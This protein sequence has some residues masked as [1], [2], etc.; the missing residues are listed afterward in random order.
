MSDE[1]EK[2]TA[3]T[4]DEVEGHSVG[5][6]V[7]KPVTRPIAAQDD[8][9]ARTSRATRCASRWR[10]RSRSPS[11]STT[12]SLGSYS[13]AGRASRPRLS[14]RVGSAGDPAA[15]RSL[16]AV[17]AVFAS[18]D[19][20]RLQLAGFCGQLGGW[21][22]WIVLSLYAYDHGGAVDGRRRRRRCGSR[23][24]RSRRRSRASIADRFPR[25][26]VL[27][28]ADTTRAACL[29]SR[30]RSTPPTG[31]RRRDR[32][33]GALR[34]RGHGVPAGALGAPAD[35]R[36]LA[37]GADRLERDRDGD[38]EREPLRSGR[39]SAA[40]SSRPAAPSPASGS[41]PAASRSR[42][43]L[44]SGSRT[45]EAPL[46]AAESAERV[47]AAAADGLRAITSN[48]GLA[49]LVG[50]FVAQ[51]FVSG[52]L[53]VLTVVLATV[54]LGSGARAGR[55]PELGDRASAASSARSARSA[56]SAAAG[57]RPCSGS[58]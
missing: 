31:R 13:S 30:R 18:P 1:N 27:L 10:S 52:A 50:L 42:R 35:A 39:R 40:S 56:S 14:A 4:D 44:S 2:P 12:F 55:L 34:D 3:K 5:K 7:A 16:S 54:R 15:R 26:R 6:P 8:D 41:A 51:T 22:Y 20:R 46:G 33:R 11:S 53:G 38:R 28:V 17:G 37:R 47:L 29:V 43:L 58:A 25:R 9:D 45:R 48:R 21:A 23:R 36:A 49:L 32:V 19:L 57:S 24:S